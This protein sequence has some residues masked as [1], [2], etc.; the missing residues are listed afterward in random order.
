M[1]VGENG[2]S[3]IFNKA[4]LN[5]R[6]ISVVLDEAH[7]IAQWG[8]FRPEYK[9]IG[10]LQS[11]LPN[12]IF[13]ITSATL[14]SYVLEDVLKILNISREDLYLLQRHNDRTNV[15]IVVR[16]IQSALNSFDDLEFLVRG[17]AANGTPPPR[18]LVLFDSIAECVSATSKL[19]ELLPPEEQDKI[20][21]HHSNMS[22]K[23]RENVIEAFKR[24]EI[25]GFCATDTLG[26]VR[27]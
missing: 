4:G 11:L 19:R 13:H 3:Q 1:R 23:Y 2:F 25:I 18:F 8:S 20:K 15:A 27:L 24:K 7:C 6:I 5:S 21:W 16:E 17:W 10:R 26:M 22:T 12:V 14:P 9:R